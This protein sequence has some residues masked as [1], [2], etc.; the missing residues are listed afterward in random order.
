MKVKIKGETIGEWPR[1]GVPTI[2]EMRRVKS[3][4]GF[5]HPARFV[6]AALS[7]D[8]VDL[9]DEFDPDALAMWVA[10]VKT[11]AGTP[12]EYED[13]DFDFADLA[14]ELTEGEKAEDA[15]AEGKG[16]PSDEPDDKTTTDESSPT[17]TEPSS[18]TPPDS[19][20]NSD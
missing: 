7:F 12:T 3:E 18:S 19:G 10:L 4:L 11:R 2:K 6:A 15:E 9:A 8:V 14:V 1:G 17:S 16:Q 5:K 13:V 20:S